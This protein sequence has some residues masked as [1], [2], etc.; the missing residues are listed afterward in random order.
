MSL[1]K[2]GATVAGSLITSKL[3]GNDSKS[4]TEVNFPPWLE[5]YM[6]QTAGNMANS[7]VPQI[8]PDNLTAALNPWIMDS[9]GQAA[10][11]AQGAGQD[12]RNQEHHRQ[13]QRALP[14]LLVREF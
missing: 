3:G 5:N 12:H 4:T 10:N 13:F 8:N 14:K 1:I 9:L 2:V 11:Y 6:T 7:P